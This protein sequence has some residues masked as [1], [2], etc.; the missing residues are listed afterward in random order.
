VSLYATSWVP[1]HIL[2][3]LHTFYFEPIFQFVLW[4]CKPTREHPVLYSL[5]T[6]RL[7]QSK[8]YVNYR[9]YDRVLTRWLTNSQYKHTFYFEPIFQ[10][11]LWVCKSPRE[12]PVLYS[13][14]Y[15]RFTLSQS[16]SLYCE[17]CKLTSIGQGAHGVAYKLTIQTERLI[18]SKTYASYRI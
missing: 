13:V 7:V 17:L 12:H 6:E 10:F 8:T 11:L 14:V 16:F 3:S 15:I 1:C 2:G 4:V 5:Q 18:Q 9:V